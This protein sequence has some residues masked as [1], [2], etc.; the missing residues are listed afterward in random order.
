MNI[1]RINNGRN[2]VNL[3]DQLQNQGVVVPVVNVQGLAKYLNKRALLTLYHILKIVAILIAVTTYMK[4]NAFKNLGDLSV[5]LSIV[6]GA[7]HVVKKVAQ[8]TK[9]VVSNEKT[10]GFAGI[11]FG[12]FAGYTMSQSRE[13]ILNP[14]RVFKKVYKAVSKMSPK[15]MLLPFVPVNPEN[16]MTGTAFG[17]VADMLQAGKA[18][19]LAMSFA[20][21]SAQA[22]LD[23]D[24]NTMKQI[25]SGSQYG[26]GITAL[27]DFTDKALYYAVNLGML[28]AVMHVQKSFKYITNSVRGTPVVNAPRR[29]APPATRLA[30]PAPPTVPRTRS[31]RSRSSIST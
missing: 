29:I 10:K 22:I 21:Q 18:L 14:E 24:T 23:M 12:T 20:E 4:S 31:S 8:V 11:I 2:V 26:F 5:K 15:N 3:V 16:V 19:S 1:A 9:L 25:Y 17:S 30:L 28:I 7:A 6:R 13:I 27:R